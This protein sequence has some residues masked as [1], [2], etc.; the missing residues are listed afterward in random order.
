[1]DFKKLG[2]IL[3]AVVSL[4]TMLGWTGSPAEIVEKVFGA[5]AAGFESVDTSQ[6]EAKQ[7]LGILSVAL[8]N[9]APDVNLTS[10]STAENTD[11]QAVANNVAKL[12]GDFA[13]APTPPAA[14]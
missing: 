11:L 2:S 6:P 10:L 7:I 8:N 12:L 14:S 3:A 5:A 9:L 13:A 4:L 1:M